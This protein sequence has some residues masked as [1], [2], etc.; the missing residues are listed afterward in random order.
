MILR[1]VLAIVTGYLLGS[2]PFGLLFGKVKARVDIRQFGSGRTGSTNVLRTMGKKAFV[3]V[4]ALDVLKGTLA[5]FLG[6]LIV[7]HGYITLGGWQ[8]DATMGQA[9]GAL[10]AVVGHIWPVF[11]RF[12]GGRGVGTFIGG[13]FALCPAAALFGGEILLIGAGLSGFASLGSISGLVAAYTIMIPLTFIYGYPWEYQAY[14]L[15]GSVLI[16][17]MHHDNIKRLM[18]GKE[19]KLNQKV[20]LS[21]Q[22]AT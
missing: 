15:L 16:I 3:T 21:H 4:A 12:K 19:R 9:L 8:I 11:A 10:A 7:G 2:I 14:A 20:E 17:A 13:M 6:G 18:S 1:F 5:A 22:Q